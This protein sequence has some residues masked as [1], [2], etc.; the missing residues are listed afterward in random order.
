MTD[1][2]DRGTVGAPPSGLAV[3]TGPH[4]ALTDRQLIE[5]I[6]RRDQAALAEAYARHGGRVL[7]LARR[8]CGS[9][10]AHDLVQEVFL[11]LWTHPERYQPERGSLRSFLLM[12]A[13]GRGVDELRS[14][15]A[16]RAR[17]S[18]DHRRGPGAADAAEAAAMIRIASRELEH[19]L[20]S[21]PP[22]ERSASVL[23]YY[24]GHSYREVASLLGEAEG[25][26]GDVAG[27]AVQRSRTSVTGVGTTVV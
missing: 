12:K 13:H 6:A 16:R 3:A 22:G 14:A 7:G 26:E 4:A 23:A 21:L 9:T 20:A 25:T 15:T 17:E 24:G 2:L 19:V 11:Q 27:A 8:L 18:A 5:A 10:G 1:V